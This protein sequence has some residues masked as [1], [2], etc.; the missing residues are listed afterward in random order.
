MGS[1]P[2]ETGWGAWHMKTNLFS[3]TIFLNESNCICFCL[4]P[5]SRKGNTYI[6][7]FLLLWSWLTE[8]WT[9]IFVFVCSWSPTGKN[10]MFIVLRDGTGFLQCVLSDKLVQLDNFPIVLF[11][12]WFTSLCCNITIQFKLGQ[13]FSSSKSLNVVEGQKHTYFIFSFWNVQNDN[14]NKAITFK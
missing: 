14:C 8:S 2:Q 3:L 5:Q 10:L 13:H 4:W 9:H 7:N 1:S 6:E 11:L 12:L